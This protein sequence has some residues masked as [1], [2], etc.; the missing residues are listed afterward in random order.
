MERTHFVAINSDAKFKN[1]LDMIAKE[2]EYKQ[3]Y[4]KSSEEYGDQANNIN[5]CYLNI[6]S[7]V[8]I[9]DNRM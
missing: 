9:K 1:R 2:F 8:K 3:E 5:Q 7:A 6:I 4:F